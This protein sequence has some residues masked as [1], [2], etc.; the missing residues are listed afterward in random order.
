[1]LS[2]R[3]NYRIQPFS[4]I[5]SSSH[6]SPVISSIRG[7]SNNRY[8]DTLCQLILAT[9]L[10]YAGTYLSCNLQNVIKVIAY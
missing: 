1:M 4:G 3:Q 2:C 10:K 6:G 7:R 9:K 5:P 8:S